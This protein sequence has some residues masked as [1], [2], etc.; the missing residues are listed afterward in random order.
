[1]IC[2]VAYRTRIRRVFG[3]CTCPTHG[4]S[5]RLP[6]PCF[7]DNRAKSPFELVHTDVWGPCRTTSI[8]GFQ[9]FVIF[10]DDYSR[11]TWL[12]LMKSR[13]E[14]YSIFQKFYV[15]IQ[16]QFNIF[17]C[18]LRSDNAREYFSAPFISFM[19]Q[20]VILHQSSF[21]HT[22][23]NGVAERKN[24]HLVETARTLLLHC[25]V[26]FRFWGDAVL[27]ACNL[28]NHMPS[29]VFHDQIP[30][31]LLFPDQPL[32]YL[33]SR[34]SC[35]TCFVH[36]LTLGQDKLSAKATKC[37][38]LGYSRLQKGYRCYSPEIHRYF[39]SAD[40]T[41]FEDSPFFSSSES[42]PIFEVLPLPIISPPIF[43][44]VLLNHFRFIIVVTV[45][46]LLSFL[47]RSLPTH[48]LSL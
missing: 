25:H 45:P 33:P 20:H 17:I 46:L 44:V 1:M 16:T 14:L 31:S 10:I 21:V 38:F 30:H 11:C 8:L 34:V 4:H 28:I 42:L 6:Y 3:V 36:I 2:H 26:P 35:C 5:T 29:F 15:E 32:Y 7:R 43:D 37:I 40:V 48:F 41:F 22:Q 19:S 18:V 13:A 27:T 9:Y 39:L 24:R 23:Q 47:L 12:F